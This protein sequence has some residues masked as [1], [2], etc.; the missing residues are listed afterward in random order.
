MSGTRCQSGSLSCCHASDFTKCLKY[1]SLPTNRQAAITAANHNIPLAAVHCNYWEQHDG[2]YSLGPNCCRSPTIQNPEVLNPPLFASC[3][4]TSSRPH[5]VTGG[6]KNTIWEDL[7]QKIWEASIRLLHPSDFTDG[8]TAGLH[9]PPN[10]RTGREAL[11]AS[12]LSSDVMSRD[13]DGCYSKSG[14]GQSPECVTNLSQLWAWLTIL[15]IQPL[16]ILSNRTGLI[17]PIPGS[18]LPSLHPRLSLSLADTLFGFS[19]KS[20]CISSHLIFLQ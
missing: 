9:G 12:V 11:L 1:F 13:E 15:T 5:K 7:H 14:S 3:R 19:G 18:T 6:R 20:I 8:R 4:L 2:P 17:H 10:R 16:L